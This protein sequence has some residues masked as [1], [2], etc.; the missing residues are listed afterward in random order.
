MTF[1]ESNKDVDA[2]TLTF[3]TEYEAPQERVWQLW[4]DPR[5]LE[6]WWGPPGY[7]ATFEVFEFEPGGRAT[8]YMTTPESTRAWGWW[9][10]VEIE[11]TGRLVLDDGFA[12]EGG[13]P[14][15][16]EPGRVTAT[17]VERDGRTRMTI[18]STF[19]STAQMEE[20]L[21]MGM[22]EGMRLALTQTD[23]ILAT[24]ISR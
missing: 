11:P 2:L 1:V 8:Y 18:L 7:P 13:A 19:A 12:E 24:E 6:R 9:R 14:R 16:G 22:E 5:Q 15:P 3:V 17:F 4:S 10:F 23:D 21:A 20:L